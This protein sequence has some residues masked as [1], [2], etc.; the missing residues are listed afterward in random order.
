MMQ[1]AGEGNGTIGKLP[2]VQSS[3]HRVHLGK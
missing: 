2:T 1:K 3:E